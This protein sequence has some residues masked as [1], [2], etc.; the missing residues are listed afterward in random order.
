MNYYPHHISDFNNATRHLSRLERSIYRDLIELYYDS[1]EPIDDDLTKI[2]RKIIAT[3]PEEKAAIEVILGEYFSLVQGFW[4]HQRCEEE[5][6]KYRDKSEKAAKA[7]KASAAKRTFNTNRTDVERPLN[8]RTTDVQP[9]NNQE[10]ITNNQKKETTKRKIS[11]PEK[12]DDVSV[13]VWSDFLQIRKTKRSPLTATALDGIRREAE[14]AGIE[15]QTALEH[16][17][18]RGWQGFQSEWLNTSRAVSQQSSETP[19]QRS[20]RNKWAE[21]TGSTLDQHL[22][23]I[24]VTPEI[25]RI[26]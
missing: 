7:G 5:I 15:L 14:K 23:V 10:P 20:M 17:C 16:C 2:A 22:N 18:S 12:P 24:D 13:S 26:A 11:H 4:F 3:T 21:A 25:A 1:E 19:Y 8:G 6:S 9:T